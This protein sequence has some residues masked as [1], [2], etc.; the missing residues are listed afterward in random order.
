MTG[1]DIA[2]HEPQTGTGTLALTGDQIEWSPVQQAA[3]AHIGIDQAPQ[4][5]QQVFL[6]VAQRTGLDPFARQIHMI[7]RREKQPDATYRTKWTIQTGIDGFRL[8]AERHPQYRGQLGPQWCGEA[9]EWQDVWLHPT[10]PP[11]AA[12]VGVLRA[13]RDGPI[14]GV[15]IF[16]EYAQTT[17]YNN[18]Q[19]L[20]RMW[21]EKGAHMIAKCFS[22]DTE[23]LTAHGFRR[24]ADV[25]DARI[26]QVTGGGLEAVNARP[27][28][29]DYDGLMVTLDSDDLN[30]S[31]TP[32]HDMITTFGKVEAAAM[33]ATSRARPVWSIPR[34]V[35]AAAGKGITATDDVIRL[36][37]VVLA[38]GH[39]HSR[40]WQVEVSRPRKV[41]ALDNLA[42]L[43][44]DRYIRSS[45]GDEATSRR[46]GRVIRS[47]FDKQ[48]YTVRAEVVAELVDDQKRL[49]LD[50]VGRMTAKQARVLVDTLVEFDGHK[51]QSSGV[52]RFY[53]SSLHLLGAFEVAAVI[54]GYTVNRPR[55]R[56]SDLSDRPNW[57]VTISPRDAIPVVRRGDGGTGLELVPNTSGRVWCVTVPSGRIVVRR[58]GFAMVCGNCAEALGVRKAFPVE[59]GGVYTEDELAGHGAATRDTAVTGRQVVT[60]AELTAAPAVV[61][62]DPEPPVTE[63]PPAGPA[64]RPAATTQKKRIA[65]LTGEAGLDDAGRYE[66]AGAMVGRVIASTG[67]LSNR[68][69]A[70]VIDGLGKLKAT[71]DFRAAVGAFLVAWREQQEAAQLADLDAERGVSGAADPDG[72]ET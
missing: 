33:Y 37:G 25:G 59:L 34:L 70:V 71:D 36:A 15:A 60:A 55:A 22:E 44:R 14:W 7:P 18:Q 42:Y 10:K 41:A 9:G 66:I 28:V 1:T 4:A 24:F 26:M 19:Q 6:H 39:R 43:C 68:E 62:A 52:R 45:R 51:V 48:G 32:N 64:A 17:T 31:V 16:R 21:R 69:A 5:D 57:C 35:P 61:D 23:V 40:D 11:V 47:N 65:I 29:R 38:D 20:T 8:I 30:F 50:V 72:A 46:S 49:R 58:H 12:R 13:D 67:E 53:T 3:L 27:F 63:P 54:A 56:S 2:V